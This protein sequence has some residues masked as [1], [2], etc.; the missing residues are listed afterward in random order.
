MNVQ[1]GISKY[2]TARQFQHVWTV[3]GICI[4]CWC[5]KSWPLAEQDCPSGFLAA[6]QRR[7]KKRLKLRYQ[8]QK[9][10]QQQQQQ[11]ERT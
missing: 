6:Q 1:K 2:R 8:Q 3:D 9:Q 10:Q 11:Q 7:D 5:Q 4:A